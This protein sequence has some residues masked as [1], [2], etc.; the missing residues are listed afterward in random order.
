MVN[1]NFQDQRA[2]RGLRLQFRRLRTAN[3]AAA[4]AD[5]AAGRGAVRNAHAIPGVA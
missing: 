3:S 5:R 4:E 2:S 1:P